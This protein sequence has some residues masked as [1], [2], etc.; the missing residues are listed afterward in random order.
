MKTFLLSWYLALWAKLFIKRTHVRII[1]VTGSVGKTTT[2]AAI[3]AVLDG[4][5]PARAIS[6]N[7]NVP[8]GVAMGILGGGWDHQ[9]ASSGGGP[10]FW[11]RASL[12]APFLALFSRPKERFVIA[13]YG[14]DR[15]GD[16]QW[17]VD[18]FPPHISVITAVGDVPVHMEYYASAKEVAA[19]KAKILSR[20]G[21]TDV[22]VLN[23]DDLTVLEMKDKLRGSAITFGTSEGAHVRAAG[24]ELLID[25]GVPEGIT[26]TIH[27]DGSALPIKLYGV[28]GRSQAYA[29]S[30]AIA[31]AYALGVEPQ[32]A[33]LGLANYRA[34]AGRMRLISGIKDSTIIDDSYNASPMA[35]HNALLALKDAPAKRR[36]AVLGD[37]LE[38][39][40]A[41]I[42]AHQAVGD[43]AGDI[44]DI[45]ICV[46]QK[47]K[48]TA[49]SAGNQMKTSDIH[50]FLTSDEAKI[51]VQD[52]IEPGDL[53]L[54]KGSQGIRTER[55]VK[56]IMSEPER[57]AQQ[58]ARQGMRWLRK[59]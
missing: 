40:K 19:E 2:H 5:A 32:E 8:F 6:G 49:D 20:L 10:W 30:A 23:A 22:A 4:V 1:A 17:L 36:I 24:I 54:V 33:V 39:G 9:Y 53:V 52:L 14:A 29:A 48:F 11:F 25:S 31:V 34:P 18:Q 28:L 45:L 15:P 27:A 58:L 35:V 21:A 26:F 59:A 41:T 56:E 47:S 37:M 46:G 42:V 3:A 50:W 51:K 57:A 7:F 13:E 12:A 38:L 44:A 16:I 43:R 55:I